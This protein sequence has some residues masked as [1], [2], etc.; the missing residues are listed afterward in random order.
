MLLK[1]RNGLAYL[2]CFVTLENVSFYFENCILCFAVKDQTVSLDFFSN[3][4]VLGNIIF[5]FESKFF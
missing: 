5:R 2:Y 1:G 4:T 3:Y